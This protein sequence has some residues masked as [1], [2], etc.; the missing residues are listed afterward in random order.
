MFIFKIS[1]IK[2][3][4]YSKNIPKIKLW[5]SDKYLR[6]HAHEFIKDKIISRVQ[7]PDVKN[8]WKY[9]LSSKIPTSSLD[10]KNEI[11]Y[12]KETNQTKEQII[13]NSIFQIEND[14]SKDDLKFLIDKFSTFT[15]KN[16][17][18]ILNK[19][20]NS[21]PIYLEIINSLSYI[22][23]IKNMIKKYPK[24]YSNLYGTKYRSSSL[25]NVVQTQINNLKERLENPFFPL[26]NEEEKIKVES[27]I[28]FL[29]MSLEKEYKF[30]PEVFNHY[31]T[32]L[33]LDFKDNGLADNEQKAISQ[34][35]TFFNGIKTSKEEYVKSVMI[36]LREQTSMKN[37][38]IKDCV[39]FAE[40]IKDIAYFYFQD[41]FIESE[42]TKS[43]RFNQL[44]YTYKY[45]PK[46]YHIKTII[47]D[48]PIYTY[49]NNQNTNYLL[50]MF[51]IL[52]LHMSGT[53][54]PFE[55]DLP[56]KDEISDFQ[57]VKNI[58]KKL[59]KMGISK[60][61][62]RVIAFSQQLEQPN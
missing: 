57:K 39:L 52:E 38:N 29:K 50:D 35:L 45:P 9:F 54:N 34:L 20:D 25:K 36:F 23:K 4:S 60:H 43:K 11:E 41:V 58:L 27:Q 48:T 42:E 44:T 13:K 32:N 51:N 5:I 56:K 61:D 21:I 47:N 24:Y 14:L 53:Q 1:C 10:Y 2:P 37:E 8:R 30:L 46:E 19:E 6:K 7:N 62:L 33:G 18:K 17:I 49:T 22:S 26:E 55:H 40:Q 59:H 28:K 3:Y 15:L 12:L 16:N 31:K